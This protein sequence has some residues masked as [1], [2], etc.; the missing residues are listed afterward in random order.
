MLQSLSFKERNIVAYL[1]SM[2]LVFSTYGWVVSGLAD[3]GRFDG[4]GAQTLL[5]ACILALVVGTIVVTLC[6]RHRLQHRVVKGRGGR[7]G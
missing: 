5:G 1:F 2:V 3:A 7:R 4:P 6:H